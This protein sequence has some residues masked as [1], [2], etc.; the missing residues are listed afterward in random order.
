MPAAPGRSSPPRS[1]QQHRPGASRC[2]PVFPECPRPPSRVWAASGTPR[3]PRHGTTTPGMHR[4]APQSQ[5]APG[6][7]E[8]PRSHSAAGQLHI[9]CG[10]EE[11]LVNGL[12]RH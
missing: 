11:P 6:R 1:G 2:L 4:A 3:A 7:G 8:R 9:N 10:A 12:K 5:R